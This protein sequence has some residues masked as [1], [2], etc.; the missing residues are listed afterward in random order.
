VRAISAGV[1]SKEPASSI[2]TSAAVST[3]SPSPSARSKCAFA[4]NKPSASFCKHA[5]DKK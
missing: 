1:L 4:L 5:T 2:A 3:P